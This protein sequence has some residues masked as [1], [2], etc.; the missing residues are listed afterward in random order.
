VTVK[1]FLLVNYFTVDY[2]IVVSCATTLPLTTF[3]IVL[4]LVIFAEVV[5][6]VELRRELA[7]LDYLPL[8]SVCRVFVLTGSISFDLAASFGFRLLYASVAGLESARLL[9]FLALFD[10]KFSVG[11]G[12]ILLRSIELGTA[13]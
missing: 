6:T 4:V 12:C 8:S 11:I 2:F 10:C 3:V 1:L 5:S 9:F 13:V 7:F